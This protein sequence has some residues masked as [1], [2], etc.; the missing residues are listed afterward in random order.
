MM[1]LREKIEANEAEFAAHGG[2]MRK[3]DNEVC[4]DFRRNPEGRGQFPRF[5]CRLSL[6]YTRY[7][8]LLAS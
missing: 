4:F 7:S 8:S 6:E 3:N 1:A 5:L 2:T